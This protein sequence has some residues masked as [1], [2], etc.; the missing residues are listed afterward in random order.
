MHVGI[1]DARQDVSAA[2]VES[3]GSRSADVR[4]HHPDDDP[5][6]DQQIGRLYAA[7][8]DHGPAGDPEVD[9][10][11]HYPYLASSSS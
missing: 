1:D 5:V 3:L 2:D 10:A 11:G 6:V 7:G 4:C 8:Q 9:G